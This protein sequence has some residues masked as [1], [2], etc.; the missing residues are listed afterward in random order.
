MAMRRWLGKSNLMRKSSGK[1][2]VTTTVVHGMP[3]S[4]SSARAAASGE[5]SRFSERV[6]TSAVRALK[7]EGRERAAKWSEER[8]RKQEPR[9][10]DLKAEGRELGRWPEPRA[11]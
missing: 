10:E 8:H 1:C 4:R 2:L 3:N 9:S 11:P 6:P 7:V 5:M